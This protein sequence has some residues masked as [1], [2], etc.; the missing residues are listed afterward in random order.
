MHHA[1]TLGASQNESPHHANRNDLDPSEYWAS[2]PFSR[3]QQPLFSPSLDGLIP[4]DHMVRLLDEILQAL[5]W[6]F[7]EQK[8]ERKR[9]QPPIHPRVV[10]SVILYGLLRRVRSS[11]QLEYL[12]NHCLD[13]LWLTEGR[14]IDH[15]TI[16][17]FRRRFSKEIKELFRQICRLAKSMGLIRLGEIMF[18]GTRVKSN[19]ARDNTATAAKLEKQIAALEEELEKLWQA[20]EAGDAADE[21]KFAPDQN[22]T[23]L[24]EDVA[25]GKARLARLQHALDRVQAMDEARRREGVDPKKNPAQIPLTD[26]DSQVMPNKEGG[27]APNYTPTAAVDAASGMIVDAVV[28]P[29]VNESPEVL[30]MVARVTETFGQAPER[31]VADAGNATGVNMSGLEQQNIEFFTPVDSNQP[32]PGDAAYREDPVEPVAPEQHEALPRNPQGQIDKSAFIYDE[33]ANVYYCP[34]GQ[35][36]KQVNSKSRRQAGGKVKQWVHRATGCAACVL[37]AACLGANA[38]Q[39]RTITRDEHEKARERTA[40]RMATPEG[41]EIYSRRLHVGETPFAVLKAMMNIR[42]FLLRGREGAET[43]WLWACTAYNLKK[44]LVSIG[45]LRAYLA[46]AAI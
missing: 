40:A 38:K 36:M 25:D 29:A 31:V 17:K 6:S 46:G 10:A 2:A 4:Q 5:D 20:W 7:W 16:C 34:M 13:F 11:R 42:Q 22:A 32:H 14:A 15:D 12:C 23:Q 8:Y 33:A 43:E 28:L 3:D 21:Q 41:R 35:T 27:Y 26:P 30:P 9:G 39:G 45:I 37:A 44:L 1:S 18:D 19:N 24:P